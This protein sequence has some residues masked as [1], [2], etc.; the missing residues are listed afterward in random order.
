M[1]P[2]LDHRSGVGQAA[3]VAIGL[4]LVALG[5]CGGQYAAPRLSSALAVAADYLDVG[6]GCPGADYGWLGRCSLAPKRGL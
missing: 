4:G 2:R 3:L 6:P 1:T 5:A